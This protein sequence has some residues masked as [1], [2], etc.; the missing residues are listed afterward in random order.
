MSMFPLNVALSGM[1]AHQQA[2]QTVASNIANASTP[3]YHRQIVR[4]ADRQ[5]S[6]SGTLV[7]G[8]GVDVIRIDRVRSALIE[9]SLTLNITTQA[10]TSARLE[11]LQRLEALFTPAEG[12]M[13]SRLQSFFDSMF[14]VTSGPNNNV[15]RQQAV[16]AAHDLSE[17]I[18]NVA[19]SMHRLQQELDAEIDTVVYRV[20]QLSG[21][22]AALN[23]D[24]G[25]QEGRGLE[26]HD[27]R[28]QRD[29]LL[30]EL[31]GLVD[32]RTWEWAG[33]PDVA[34]YGNGSV[35][36]SNRSSTLTV[37]AENGEVAIFS[38]HSGRRVSFSGG[39]LAGLLEARNEIVPAT[40]QRLQDFTDAFVRQVDQLQATGLGQNGSL[41]WL[42]STRGVADIND[43]LATAGTTFPVDEGQ[44]FVSVTDLATGS[45][46]LVAIDIDPATDSL[47]DVASAIDAIDHLQTFVDPQTGTFDIRADNGYAFDFVGRLETTPDVTAVT[48][49]SDIAISGRY[50]GSANDTLEFTVVGSGQVGVTSGLQVEVR[51]SAGSLLKTV[52]VGLGYEPGAALDAGEGVSISFNAGTLNAGDTFETHIVANADTAGVLSALGLQTFFDGTKVGLMS[53]QEDVRENPELL[54]VSLS[55]L[56]GDGDHAA[57]FA[58]LRDQLLMGGGSLTLEEY[59]A[60]TSAFIGGDVRNTTN[61]LTHL[62]AMGAELEASRESESG[63][64]PNEELVRM[65]Q[66]QRG[67]QAAAKVISTMNQMLDDVFTIL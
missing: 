28:D 7:L 21:Q 18:N 17:E 32:V 9:Q 3:G 27:L 10:N 35:S 2:L 29:Q 14:A 12:G 57:K 46:R 6:L 30:N 5:P 60:E 52:D 42:E 51:N 33:Q 13:Q 61:A 40:L 31:A 55:G 15:L 54:S 67:F 44:L 56:P 39:R 49:T 65:L 59:L 53:V 23:T 48:G 26:P 8:A 58:A 34:V 50:T 1:Q 19:T 45:R 24:I 20:N 16:S 25:I 22:I 41:T 62:E 37:G 64:D 47:A 36:L 43:P 38:D 11:S 63:V 4:F 66:Y